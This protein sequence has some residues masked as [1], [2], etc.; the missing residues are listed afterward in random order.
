MATTTTARVDARGAFFE[1]L[2]A[3][4]PARRRDEDDDARPRGRFARAYATTR[5]LKSM[6]LRRPR[7]W[8]GIVT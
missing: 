3:L 8:C 1:R 5:R 6:F 4:A 7:T 2:H